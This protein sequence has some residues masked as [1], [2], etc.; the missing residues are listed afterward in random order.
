MVKRRGRGRSVVVVA[1]LLAAATVAT[2]IVVGRD[3]FLE[4]WYIHRLGSDSLE[5]RQ[6]AG[7]KLAGMGSV[8]AAPL[9]VK[10]TRTEPFISPGECPS[11]SQEE[12]AAW[13]GAGWVYECLR[14]LGAPAVPGLANQVRDRSLD[15]SWRRIAAR[16]LG[17]MGETAAAAVPALES[18]LDEDAEGGLGLRFHAAVALSRIAGREAGRARGVLEELSTTPDMHS[19]CPPDYEEQV[20]RAL[21]RIAGDLGYDPGDRLDPRRREPAGGMRG[22]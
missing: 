17:S 18:C 5:V 3:A 4:P 19:D 16:T 20:A 12:S 10:M 8:R 14:D 6:A 15:E 11:G 21:S 1:S 22:E 13:E 2:A 7:R 9:L